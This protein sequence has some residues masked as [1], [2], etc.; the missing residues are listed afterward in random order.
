MQAR[1]HIVNQRLLTA[2]SDFGKAQ[3]A[4]EAAHRLFQEADLICSIC[5][6]PIGYQPDDIQ[7]LTCNHFYHQRYFMEL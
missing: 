3:Q 5:Q 7:F 1:C 6:L 2:N 4:S